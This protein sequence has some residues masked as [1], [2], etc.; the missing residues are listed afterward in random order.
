MDIPR[1]HFLHDVWR[2]LGSAK[3]GFMSNATLG[4]TENPNS[5][6][7][8]REYL[9]LLSRE[10]DGLFTIQPLYNNQVE[11]D[12]GLTIG[13]NYAGVFGDEHFTKLQALTTPF[14]PNKKTK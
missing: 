7:A 6:P 12:I 3:S 2:S 5:L 10:G 11:F 4:L 1:V 14:V 9:G 8:I 13:S